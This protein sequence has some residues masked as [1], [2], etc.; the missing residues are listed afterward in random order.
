MPLFSEQ[1]NPASFSPYILTRLV[2]IHFYNFTWYSLNCFVILNDKLDF[3][4][5]RIGVL[6]RLWGEK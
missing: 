4:R 3:M 5:R 2:E 1:D 6:F